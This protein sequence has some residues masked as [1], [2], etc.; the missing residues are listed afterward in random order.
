MSLSLTTLSKVSPPAPP[1][2]ILYFSTLF[3]FFTALNTSCIYFICLFID[4]YSLPTRKCEFRGAESTPVL[5]NVNTVCLASGS[6][7][8]T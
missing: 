3:V 4:I 8:G 5:I 1:Q 7:F 6:S 2:G